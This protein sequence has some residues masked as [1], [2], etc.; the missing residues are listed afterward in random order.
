MASIPVGSS[1]TTKVID[2]QLQVVVYGTATATEEAEEEDA[3]E[4]GDE[5]E[6]RE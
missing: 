6:E 4:V 2:G 5:D 1:Y 3:G